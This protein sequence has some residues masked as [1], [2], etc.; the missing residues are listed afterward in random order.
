MKHLLILCAILPL[1]GCEVTDS[2]RNT[3][4]YDIS[5]PD[6]GLRVKFDEGVIIYPIEMFN[7]AWQETIECTEIYG[8]SAPY[9]AVIADNFDNTISGY[10]TNVDMV[11]QIE[12]WTL[13]ISD[14]LQHEMIHY[15][16]YAS[17][18]FPPRVEAHQS[19][20]F[21]KCAP[22]STLNPNYLN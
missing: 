10:T 4:D 12:G 1:W 17:G 21:D 16:L 2:G 19:Y 13:G 11:I 8:Y 3:S 15:L 9:I 5:N 6:T 18:W 14:L 7:E 20:L 22:R